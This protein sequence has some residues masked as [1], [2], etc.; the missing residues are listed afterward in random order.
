M[1]R[2][3]GDGNWGKH[4]SIKKCYSKQFFFTFSGQ[5]IVVEPGRVKDRNKSGGGP[6]RGGPGGNRSG[7]HGDRDRSSNRD[8]GNRSFDNNQ[9][10]PMRRDRNFQQTRNS[11]PYQKGPSDGQG[12]GRGYGNNGK[13]FIMK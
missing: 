10:G 7:S 6:N 13:F 2:E 8:G 12:G 5:S 11:G 4:H 9:G 1:K 3:D